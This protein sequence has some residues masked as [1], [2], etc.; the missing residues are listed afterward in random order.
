[1][2][3]SILTRPS[4]Q[5]NEQL[6]TVKKI[7]GLPN[8]DVYIYDP[9]SS[10]SKATAP[11]RS[12]NTSTTVNVRTRASI[13]AH[14]PRTGPRRA[15]HRSCGR[16]SSISRTTTRCF[17]R[18]GS[19]TTRSSWVLNA[20]ASLSS[21]SKPTAVARSPSSPSRIPSSLRPPLSTKLP[22]P[23]PRRTTHC[24]SVVRATKSLPRQTVRAS[25]A[26]PS[27]RRGRSWPWVRA[28]PCR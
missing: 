5:A 23:A 20:T 4:H 13:A 11:N 17:A 15:R 25:A 28:T 8:C 1:M 9:F 19:R 18:S 14:R 6:V 16:R 24:S 10:A 26:W 21:M 12:T 3:V 7:V 27:I 22:K 2:V